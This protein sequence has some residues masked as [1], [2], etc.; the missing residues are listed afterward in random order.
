[1]SK[2][3]I[4]MTEGNIRNVLISFTS[5]FVNSNVVFMPAAYAIS[6]IVAMMRYRYYIKI[7]SDSKAEESIGTI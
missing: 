5:L 3:T 2:K 6:G 4:I 1:M 7:K